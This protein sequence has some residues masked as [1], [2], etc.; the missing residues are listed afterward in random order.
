MVTGGQAETAISSCNRLM[1]WLQFTEFPENNGHV[2]GVCVNSIKEHQ[3]DLEPEGTHP[4][5]TLLE[6]RGSNRHPQRAWR[7]AL[8]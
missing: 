3:L 4:F 1:K 6:V 7:H 2:M 8:C 5:F